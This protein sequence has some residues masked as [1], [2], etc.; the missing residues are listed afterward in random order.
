MRAKYG[1]GLI[2]EYSRRL[3]M[4]LGHGYSSR[5]LKRVRK[6]YLLFSKGTAVPTL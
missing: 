5:N 3:T 4:E 6:F 1:D 2:K